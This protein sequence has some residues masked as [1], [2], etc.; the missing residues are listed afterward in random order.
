MSDLEPENKPTGTSNQEEN[1]LQPT[2]IQSHYE[3]LASRYVITIYRQIVGI[4]LERKEDF[5]SQLI[6]NALEEWDYIAL[7]L[8]RA[9]IV[10]D[11]L[12]HA[13]IL[14]EIRPPFALLGK[15]S[16]DA[17]WNEIIVGAMSDFGDPISQ[18]IESG[19]SWDRVLRLYHDNDNID[20]ALRYGVSPDI[21]PEMLNRVIEQEVWEINMHTAMIKADNERLEK[22]LTDI[23]GK[24]VKSLELP[25][26]S[27]LDDV[28]SYIFS[29]MRRYL[30]E[31]YDKSPD[32]ITD[33]DINNFLEEQE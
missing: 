11:E 3:K 9:P 12:I 30:G 20:A 10:E 24:V 21:S 17:T 18:G 25:K 22:E 28:N 31:L 27:T 29:L 33:E 19:W 5:D 8:D 2:S 16:E 1:I 23:R 26:D 15:L 4:T 7:C 6:E 13:N 14:E 32:D